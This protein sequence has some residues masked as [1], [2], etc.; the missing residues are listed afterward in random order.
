MSVTST[1]FED[2]D[3]LTNAFLNETYSFTAYDSSG[4]KQIGQLVVHGFYKDAG[5]ADVSNE[6]VAYFDTA[7]SSGI[8][9]CVAR[10]RIHFYDDVEKSRT[11]K[12]LG[13]S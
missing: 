10:V 11:V 7:S 1:R 4:K 13:A 9:K 6:G 3:D 8:F 2:P 12:F 5:V